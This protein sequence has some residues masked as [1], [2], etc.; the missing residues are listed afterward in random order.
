MILNSDFDSDLI[1]NLNFAM[2]P[3]DNADL[4]TIFQCIFGISL[5][6]LAVQWFR[7]DIL[8]NSLEYVGRHGTP[9]NSE[10]EVSETLP[11]KILFWTLFFSQ[12]FHAKLSHRMEAQEE[13]DACPVKCIFTH[14]PNEINDSAAVIFHVLDFSNHLI[15]YFIL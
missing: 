8:T 5:L 12:E 1:L 7:P 14:D 4:K 13:L 15:N 6:I 2:K 11:Q 3:I 10:Y 9:Y